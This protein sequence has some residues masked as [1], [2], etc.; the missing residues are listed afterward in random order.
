[1]K[2]KNIFIVTIIVATI[3]SRAIITAVDNYELKRDMRQ[4]LMDAYYESQETR[5]VEDIEFENILLE[6]IEVEEI[7]IQ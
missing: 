3:I 1:M 4:R 6:T 2:G 5:L 7:Q